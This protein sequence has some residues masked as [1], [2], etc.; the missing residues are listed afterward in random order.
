MV[1]IVAE[2]TITERDRWL[3]ECGCL[4]G[5]YWPTEAVNCYGQM[6]RN[7]LTS[8]TQ[9]KTEELRTIRLCYGHHQAQSRLP[10]GEAY[11]KGSKT[12]RA[13]YGTDDELLALQNKLIE[14]T[15]AR[16]I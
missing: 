4:I 8:M 11:H 16:L 12:F 15:K 3:K 5:H 10:V 1:V 9:R 2:M 6:E 14:Q 7:H 13:K